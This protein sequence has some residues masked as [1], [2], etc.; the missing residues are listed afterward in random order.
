VLVVAVQRVAAQS[1]NSRDDAKKQLN[2]AQLQSIWNTADVVG[3]QQKLLNE[4]QQAIDDIRNEREVFKQQ[5]NNL[6][7]DL[8]ALR[9]RGTI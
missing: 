8:K 1:T 9:K 4:H 3:Q 7:L 5:L 6:T 2:D